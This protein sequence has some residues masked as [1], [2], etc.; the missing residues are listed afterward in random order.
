MVVEAEATNDSVSAVIWIGC[1]AKL[2]CMTGQHVA[3]LEAK[4]SQYQ[5]G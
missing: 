3:R 5:R 2:T 1:S 4:A